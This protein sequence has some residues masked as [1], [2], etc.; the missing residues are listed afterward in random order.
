MIMN[1]RVVI[2][3][4]IFTAALFVLTSAQA[5][6]ANPQQTL[7]QYIS[8]L[9]KNPNDD[10]LRGK[11]IALVQT[12]HPAPAIPEEARGHYVMASTF[13]EKAKDDTERAKDNSG[14]KQAATGFKRA[15]GEYKAALLA[16]PWWADAYKKL[17]IAQKAA[18]KY[19]DAVAS[20]NFYLLTQ[21]ADARDA[22]DEIYK[23]K[24]LR[25]SAVDD[26]K[27]AEQKAAEER[28]RRQQEEENSPQGKFEALLKKINGRRY[29]WSGNGG[30]SVL[31]VSGKVL[32]VGAF[33]TGE[34]Y[35]TFPPY[36]V[37]I[38]GRETTVAM[39]PVTIVSRWPV[40][41][42]Y[43]ISE[44]GTLITVR[45]RLNDGAVVE[46]IHLWQR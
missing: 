10:A 2:R 26:R 46:E 16:A 44:D 18:K 36:R 6:T 42:T 30:T 32:V 13:A 28:Q 21:P 14:L 8:D 20:L 35:R 39:K 37:E 11:I 9:Q 15:I 40:S 19:D 7:N 45:S 1:L 43:V 41:R 31:D 29:T 34:A 17:A 3:I 23:L 27:L 24:A 25:E 22:Q 38:L 4:V 33:P 12:M 5:Q